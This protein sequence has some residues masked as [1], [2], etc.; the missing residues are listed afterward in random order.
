MPRESNNFE[1]DLAKDDVII[2]LRY[3]AKTAPG[4]F[5]KEVM[6]ALSTL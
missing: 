1:F 4:A 3:T 5:K 2:H 6:G